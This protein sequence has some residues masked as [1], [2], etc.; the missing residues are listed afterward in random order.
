V[1]KQFQPAINFFTEPSQELLEALRKRIDIVLRRFSL[2]EGFLPLELKA[3]KFKIDDFNSRYIYKIKTR[4]GRE[5]L[6]FSTG[7][8]AQVA[9]SLLTAQNLAVSHLLSH[10]II[11]LDDVTTAYDLSNLTREAI[12]WRQLAYGGQDEQSQRQVF[13]SSHHE[14]MTNHLL[15]LLVPPQGKEMRL[16]RF[17]DWSA[18][19]GPVYQTFRIEPT[20]A[21]G[22]K[23][24]FNRLRDTLA[25]QLAAL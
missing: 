23:S 16:I 3:E 14:D 21:T 4:D 20:Q 2:V 5:L 18:D 7:Q 10:R 9:V 24:Q 12:L 13:I 19:S 15:D 11:L 22:T 1:V 17:T 25:K 8:R 6:H